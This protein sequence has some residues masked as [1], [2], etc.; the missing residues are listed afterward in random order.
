M[1]EIINNRKQRIEI[2][3]GPAS[4]L[5]GAGQP[6]GLVNVITKKAQSTFGGVVAY[7]FDN[8]GLSRPTVD[9]T[10]PANDKLNYRMNFAYQDTDTFRD[11]GYDDRLFLAPM[12]TYLLGENTL[13]EFQGQYTRDRANLD[14]GLVVIDGN[15][16]ALPI[17]RNLNAPTDF[18]RFNDYNWSSLEPEA[19]VAWENRYGQNTWDQVRDAVRHAW[20]S[21]K[22]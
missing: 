21:A 11:F 18:R 16:R 19:R 2:M 12:F 14:S 1:S 5:Y 10:G 13:L 8:F 20:E 3:K 6:S 15:P 22:G 9:V 7:Q 17:E 4:V